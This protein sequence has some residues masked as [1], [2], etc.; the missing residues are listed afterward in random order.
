MGGFLNFFVKFAYFGIVLALVGL[1]V[2]ARYRKIDEE[3]GT[4]SIVPKIIG[5]ALF[6]LGM[7]WVIGPFILKASTG[8][9]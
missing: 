7:I 1:F 9:L 2:F 4:K 8:N 3:T 5:V 6:A